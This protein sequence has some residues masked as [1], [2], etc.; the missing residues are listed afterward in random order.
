MVGRSVMILTEGAGDGIVRAHPD[1]LAHG[2][3]E[4]LSKMRMRGGGRF[5]QTTLTEPV[6]L[7]AGL[8]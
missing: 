2:S 7:G 5:P 8:R 3:V 4:A 1:H 6:S